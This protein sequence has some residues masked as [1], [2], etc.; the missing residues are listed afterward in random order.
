[1]AG[2]FG[3][4]H[5]VTICSQDS[6]FFQLITENVQIL[7]YRGENSVLCNERYIEEKLGIRPQQYA[8]YKSL[9]GDTA[10]NIRGADKVG[11]KTAAAL[12][13]EFGDLENLL[14]HAE[15]VK[16]PS[17]RASLLESR[18]RLQKNRALICLGGC[19]EIPFTAEEMLFSD[20][21]LSTM[22]VLH[23]IGVQ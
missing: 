14:A 19:C 5:K 7:R 20:K 23:R 17:V 21:G 22:Q 8:D 18:E 3:K 15:E 1:M 11:P 9:T 4:D 2:R 16:K 13:T 12:M 6:D 10:D